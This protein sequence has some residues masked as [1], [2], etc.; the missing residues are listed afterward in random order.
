MCYIFLFFTRSALFPMIIGG[1][2]FNVYLIRAAIEITLIYVVF[3]ILLVFNLQ[4]HIFILKHL[5]T[6]RNQASFFLTK[7]TC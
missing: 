3:I 5:T 1:I 4:I 7:I 2:F 6:S